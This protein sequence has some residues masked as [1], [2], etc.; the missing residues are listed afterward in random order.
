MMLYILSLV[1]IKFVLGNKVYSKVNVGLYC[2]FLFRY[3]FM[4]NEF[5]KIF[6][7]GG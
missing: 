5:F 2:F 4:I 6:M 7:K 1:S 3:L